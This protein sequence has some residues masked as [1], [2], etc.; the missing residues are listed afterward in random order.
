MAFC[1]QKA[2]VRKKQELTGEGEREKGMM[3]SPH[4]FIFC[5]SS[6]TKCC[7]GDLSGD[8]DVA[9]GCRG[10]KQENLL[11]TFQLPCP[12]SCGFFLFVCLFVFLLISFLPALAHK[13][14]ENA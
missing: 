7:Y 6:N 5:N 2:V 1:C 3:V 8:W 13:G 14:G 11:A 4:P 9:A 10:N 12:F